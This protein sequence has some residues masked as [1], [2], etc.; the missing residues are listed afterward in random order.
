MARVNKLYEKPLISTIELTDKVTVGKLVNGE[1]KVKTMLYSEFLA[2][3]VDDTLVLV[4]TRAELQALI[5]SSVLAI[6]VRYII[7]NAVGS[8]L[9]LLTQAVST[10][11][12]DEIAVNASNGDNVSYDITTDIATAIQQTQ[13][14]GTGFVKASGTTLSYDNSTYLTTIEGIAAGGE[15]EGNYASPTLKNSSVIGKVLT[16]LSVTG[17]AV[18]STDSVLA[19]I[20]KLQ[21]QVNGLAGG[22]EYQGT[23]NAST[24]TPTLTSS[25]G[26]Q[27]FYYVVSVAGSTN[28]NGIT[29]WELG[30]WAIFN[31]AT[32]Q[33]VD[34]TDA[35]VSVNGY[36]GIVTLSA[37]DIG[38][39]P[40]TR[41]VNTTSPLTGGGDLTADLTLSIPQSSG[42]VNGY[43]ASTDWTTF[44]NKQNALTNPITGTGTTN[45]LPKFTASS[46]IGNSLLFDDG[47]NVGI[48][49]TSP[50]K[51][52]DLQ[53]TM[54]M[55]GASGT[56]LQIQYAGANRGYL[57]TANEIIPS[58]STADFGIAAISNLLFGSGGS[59]TERMRIASSGNLL[60]NT[61]TDSGYKLD[62]NGTA[63]VSGAATFSSSVTLSGVLEVNNN[64]ITQ[65]GTRPIFTLKQSGTSKLLLGISAG[66]SDIIVGDA[67]G[68]VDFRTNTQAFNFSVDNGGSIAFKLASSGAATFSSSVTAGGNSIITGADRP[69]ELRG[70]GGGANSLLRFSD[71]ATAKFSTGF[72]SGNYIIY[73]DAN[74]AYRLQIN[75]STG[76]ATFSSSVTAG[77]ITI[78]SGN[79]LNVVS[80]D[81]YIQEAGRGILSP[82]ASRLLEIRNGEFGVNGTLGVT[83]AATFS[84]SVAIGNTV[85]ASVATPSTHK[86]T[87]VIGGVTY[88]LLATNV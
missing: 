71:G 36:T 23:W 51:K 2:Q 46:T 39:V 27:G 79:I 70:A 11:V 29:S 50:S 24:N 25:V 73:D 7:T 76:A 30:D 49:T 64:A 44:N 8:T 3:I 6:G 59:L 78:T 4:V 34:N 87:M 69:L 88:Y 53:G 86:V 67:I 81:I 77:T 43:L 12:L 18:V 52:L 26:T 62:V 60:L 75:G 15:L 22:V 14:N 13:I 85:S 37:S 58:G 66:A 57:G 28:L 1:Y 56:Y 9:S 42:S 55:N 40:T 65:D 84:S 68:D 32:W 41:T 72:N 17:S 35:V 19:A 83:G 47:T 80:G 45:Y 48:G 61:T 74:L 5:A 63:R 82:N 31:G 10:T 33:K 38:A 54:N 21:N 20:G 16:G